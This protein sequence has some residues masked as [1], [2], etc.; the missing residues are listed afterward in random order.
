MRQPYTINGQN[1][2]YTGHI[3]AFNNRLGSIL[4]SKHLF[5][6]AFCTLIFFKSL[7][8][9]QSYRQLDKVFTKKLPTFYAIFKVGLVLYWPQKETIAAYFLGYSKYCLR[10]ISQKYMSYIETASAILFTKN[11]E[12]ILRSDV[13]RRH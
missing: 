13:T 5:L 4:Q 6:S 12:K 10:T 11:N 9:H 3:T 7:I 2:I 8:F 1:K